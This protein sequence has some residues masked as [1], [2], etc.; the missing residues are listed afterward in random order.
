MVGVYKALDGDNLLDCVTHLCPRGPVA[1][2]SGPT[3]VRRGTL[4]KA[5]LER[6]EALKAQTYGEPGRHGPWAKNVSLGT[7]IPIMGVIGITASVP[8]THPT[9]CKG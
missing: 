8:V 6:V 2:S 4:D 5:W 1:Y 9:P 3:G 7:P